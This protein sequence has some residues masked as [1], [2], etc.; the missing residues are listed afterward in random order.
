MRESLLL[1]LGFRI[2]DVLADNW[3]IFLDFHLVRH[4]ALVL[5]CGIEVPSTCT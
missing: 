3:I 2:D 5:F 4:I 1:D